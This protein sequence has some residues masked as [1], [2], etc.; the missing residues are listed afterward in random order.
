MVHAPVAGVHR[1]AGRL[2]QP[3]LAED[4]AVRVADD[5]EREEVLQHEQVD[6]VHPADVDTAPQLRVVRRAHVLHL[7]VAAVDGGGAGGGGLGALARD[8]VGEGG[9]RAGED[10]EEPDGGHEDAGDG[11]GAARPQRVDDGDEAVDGNDGQRENADVDGQRLDERRDRAERVRQTPVLEDGRLELER[12]REDAERRV[13][14]RQ[15]GDEEVRDGPHVASARDHHHDE[16]VSDDG[17]DRDGAVQQRQGD[18]QQRRH[19]VVVVVVVVVRRRRRHR[20]DQ[21]VLRDV[22]RRQRDRPRAT[23]AR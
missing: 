18:E 5:D 14:R 11:G 2:R 10:A 7:A 1:Q 16:R 21:P 6:V 13:G 23:A 19:A 3:D 4:A 17:E 9:G 12:R 15:V 8:G 20:A 22:E